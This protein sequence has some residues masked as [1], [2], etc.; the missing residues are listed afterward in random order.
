MANDTAVD[1]KELVNSIQVSVVR[2]LFEAKPKVLFA[3]EAFY[4]LIGYKKA[5][6]KAVLLEEVFLNKKRY[7]DFIKELKSSGHV[8]EFEVSLKSKGKTKQV[9]WVVITAMVINNGKTKKYIDLTLSDITLHK[10]YEKDLLE[11]KEL[12]RTVFNKTA[13][14]IT[15]TDKAE[16]IMA[17]NPFT[18]IML[19]MTKEELFN[20]PVKELYPDKE[21]KKLR[22]FRIRKKGMLSDIETQVYK[23]DGTLLDVN[24]SISILKNTEGEIVGSIGILR[25]ITSQK[26]AERKLRESENKI[27]V[28]LD[29]SAAAMTLIDDKE[30]MLSWNKY[31]EQLLGMTRQE[32]YLRPLSTIYPKE[33]WQKIRGENIRKM[34]SK[35]HLETQ[36]ITKGGKIIDIDLS[37]N[38]LRDSKDNI[39]G[40]VGIMQD[41]TEQKKFKEMLLQAKLSAEEANSAKSLFLANMSHEVRTPMNTI[42]GMIDLTLDTKLDEEQNENLSVA[43]DAAD[44][45]LGLINDILDLSR[46]EAGRIALESIEFHLVNV[47]NSVCKGLSVLANKK[48]LDIKVDIEKNVPELIEGDPVRLRQIL[49]NLINNAIK[50]THKGS[51]T[52]NVKV[53]KKSDNEIILHFAIIDT[54]IGIPKDRQESV[55]DV[56]TQAD[57]STTRQFGGTGLGLAI[58]KKL[59]D[60]MGGQIWVESK[61]GK[62]SGF[63]FTGS[64][65]L[66]KGDVAGKDI[67]GAKQQELGPDKEL[68]DLKVLLAEDN[69]VNQKIAVKMFEKFG[70]KVQAVGDG[71]SVIDEIIKNRFDVVFMDAE[72]PI[73]DGLEATKIIRK[74]EESTGTHIPIIAF[75]ARAMQ[76][77]RKRFMDA[78]MDGYVSKPINRKQL[79]DEVKTVMSNLS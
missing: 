33:E 12:F 47:V 34:G 51:V 27:R 76:E 2:C 75:T 38:V 79:F 29:N 17:W 63:H 64:F 55:F 59:T 26:E 73:L 61:P 74:N 46:V 6:V 62:G 1:L 39:I 68:I 24:L 30:R 16:R 18:E 31:T 72:M 66:V 7:T 45:L 67:Y 56:F 32:L 25:D 42:I 40:S 78:G 37:V 11:S 9:V 57:E 20:K 69:L 8:R 36:I 21:W 48:G 28:I 4:T 19:G 52:V 60:M 22:A 70:W 10:K 14:T 50:F 15:V 35:H 53:E 43:K 5:P 54:G 77:D 41:I 65:K 3:N 44:N 13:A 23:K 49:I 71:Q 58:C